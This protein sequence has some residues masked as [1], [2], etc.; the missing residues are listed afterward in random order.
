MTLPLQ[1][2]TVV[3]MFVKRVIHDLRETVLSYIIDSSIYNIDTSL[4]LRNNLI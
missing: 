1:N 4:D 3:V 2:L